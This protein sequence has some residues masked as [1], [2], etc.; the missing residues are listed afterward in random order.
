MLSQRPVRRSS[1]AIARRRAPW[2]SRARRGSFPTAAPAAPSARGGRKLGARAAPRADRGGPPRGFPA[3]WTPPPC[4]GPGFRKP[5]GDKRASE[6]SARAWVPPLRRAK[7]D[8]ASRVPEP[9]PPRAAQR[10]GVRHMARRD[11]C[12]A[13]PPLRPVRATSGR[14]D[15]ASLRERDKREGAE[16]ACAPRAPIAARGINRDRRDRSR[17]AP[18]RPGRTR[19]A[20]ARCFPC[21]GGRLPGWSGRYRA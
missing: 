5:A 17:R 3:G 10:A 12:P 21:R 14:R 9:S 11:P 19:R 1:P 8:R 13:A 2:A 6:A 18:R 4:G 16:G 20:A 15:Q 7:E